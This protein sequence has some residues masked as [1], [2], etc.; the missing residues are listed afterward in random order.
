MLPTIG[1][2]RFTRVSPRYAPTHS[3]QPSPASSQTRFFRSRGQ[4]P[5][6]LLR[7]RI[8]KRRSGTSS[9]S[10]PSKQASSK[11]GEL[12]WAISARRQGRPGHGSAVTSQ[13]HPPRSSGGIVD[14]SPSPSVS[15]R[16]KRGWDSW[17]RQIGL[18][19]TAG[20]RRAPKS[21]SGGGGFE[22]SE[23]PRRRAAASALC[24]P[25]ATQ[26]PYLA[27]L[28]WSRPCAPTDIGR[29]M[30]REP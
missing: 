26:Q 2:S 29:K 4:H 8:C 20:P 30:P 14:E 13:K 9:G 28:R 17:R 25:A 7:S 18:Q 10:T 3:S 27:A 11:D 23:E 15:A 6:H 21:R 22:R 16:T 24:V 19:M 5:S 1:R 12:S